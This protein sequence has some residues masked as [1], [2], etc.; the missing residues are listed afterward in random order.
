MLAIVTRTQGQAKGL[1][2]RLLASCA[3]AGAILSGGPAHASATM[4]PP[5]TGADTAFQ[6]IGTVVQ[7]TAQIVQ[8]PTLDTITVSTADTII[9]FTPFDTANGGG[10]ITFLPAGR[11]GLFQNDP[12]SGVTNFTVL[13]RIVPTDA[14]RAI[15]FD[16]TVQSRIADATGGSAPGGRILFYSPGGIIA[17]SSSVFDV[18]SLVLS[19]A[20][21]TFSGPNNAFSFNSA[22]PGTAVDINNGASILAQGTGSF[23]ALVAPRIIQSGS[24]R[25][26]GSVA[27][28][29]AEAVDVTIQNNLFNISFTQ[30]TDG[31]TAVA[32]NG[33]TEL[34][35]AAGDA[36]PQRIYIAAVPKNDAITTLV[37]GT[38]GYS[39]ATSASIQN[40]AVILSAGRDVS[41]SGYGTNFTDFGG[42]NAPANI[43][44]GADSSTIFNASLLTNATGDAL[45]APAAG[46]TIAF[47][48][49]VIL[50]ADRLAEV[51]TVANSNA[52]FA[53]NLS[54]SSNNLVSDA[55]ARVIALG[56]AGYGDPG[57][58]ST[59]GVITVGG[60][61]LINGGPSL[62]ADILQKSVA[63]LIADRG[64]ISIGGTTQ[65]TAA[66]DAF[67][68]ETLNG[69]GGSAL[70]RVGAAGSQLSLG[71]LSVSAGAVAGTGFDQTQTSID[72]SAT[73][74]SARIEVAGGS[75]TAGNITVD[76]DAFGRPG[77][78]ATAG[79]SAFI[80]SGGSIDSALL[81][82]SAQ[83]SIANNDDAPPPPAATAAQQQSQNAAASSSSQMLTGGMIQLDVVDTTVNVDGDLTLNA[84]ANGSEGL[85]GLQGGTIGITVDNGSLNVSGSLSA[86]ASAEESASQLGVDPGLVRGGMITAS[87]VN[88]GALIASTMDY[89]ANAASGG[90]ATGGAVSLTTNSGGSIQSVGTI[91]VAAAAAVRSL[92][93]AGDATGGALLV[94]INSGAL[95]SGSLVLDASA[96]GG[97]AILGGVGGSAT[98]GTARVNISSGDNAIEMFSL[99]TNASGGRGGNADG[100]IGQG[101]AGGGA[102]AGT[103]EVNISGGAI[104]TAG[105]VLTSTAQGGN[106]G[107]GESGGAG[108][109]ASGGRAAVLTSEAS[110]LRFMQLGS[111]ALTSSVDA[112][113]RGGSGGFGDLMA[114]G[115]GGMAAGGTAML[116]LAGA[117]IAANTPRFAINLSANSEAAGGIGGSSGNS[118]GGAGGSAL[119][120]NA[121]IALI[122]NQIDFGSVALS[123]RGSGG[124]GGSAGNAGYGSLGTG[125]AG[126]NG[127]GGAASVSITAPATNM[128]A[129]SIANLA[130]ATEAVGGS[131]GAGITGGNG[132]N[133]INNGSANF[134]HGGGMVAVPVAILTTNSFGG[135]GGSGSGGTDGNGGNSQ[136][137]TAAISAD[138][139]STNLGITV[140]GLSA[141]ARGGAGENG[142]SALGGTTGFNIGGGATFAGSILGLS[143]DAIV[144]T[145]Q[146]NIA[147]G[148]A[149]GGSASV[150]I[151]NGNALLTGSLQ[152]SANGDA[153]LGAGEG[154]TVGI[155]AT[156]GTLS[157]PSTIAS[158]NGSS[159]V[160]GMEIGGRGGGIN[161]RAL[162][163]GN[164][165]AGVLNLGSADLSASGFSTLVGNPSAMGNAAAG[166]IDIAAVGGQTSAANFLTLSAQTLGRNASGFSPNSGVFLTADQGAI[167]SNN[168]A[169]LLSDE[170]ITVSAMGTGNLFVGNTLNAEAL[171]MISVDHIGRS[172]NADTILAANVNLDAGNDVAAMP[173]TRIRSDNDLNIVSRMGSVDAHDLVA[174]DDIAVMANGAVNI[175]GLAQTTGSVNSGYGS[176]PSDIIIDS[177]GDVTLGSI[178]ANASLAVR[179]GSINGINLIAGEDIALRSS[180]D[181]MVMAG[182]AGDDIDVTT[183]GGAIGFGS[184]TTTG[185]G[186]DNRRAMLDSGIIGFGA[187]TF[188][189]SNILANA[190]AGISVTNANAR[191]TLGLRTDNIINATTLVAGEDA[192]FASSGSTTIGSV[193][194]GDDID[195]NAGGAITVL[196]ATSMGN[197]A[198]DR[199]VFLPVGSAFFTEENLTRSNIVAFS[200]TAVTLGSSA[201]AMMPEISAAASI[202]VRSEG[203]I[204][205]SNIAAGEDIAL[206]ATGN[207]SV[208][209]ASAGD[210]FSALSGSGNITLTGIFTN[211]NGADDRAVDFGYGGIG[212]I[213]STAND[214]NIVANAGYGSIS[215]GTLNA[216]NDL[217]A[218][219]FTITTV[220]TGG[221]GPSLVAGRDISLTGQSAVSIND[222]TAGRGFTLNSN[223]TASIANVT[224]GD[225]ILISTMGAVN[226]TGLLLTNGLGAS[227]SDS[228]IEVA[229]GDSFTFNAINAKDNFLFSSGSLSGNSIAAGNAV[230]IS[231]ASASANAVTTNAGDIAINAVN[232]SL[233]ATSAGQDLIID[234]GNAANSSITLL[235]TSAAR[236]IR[237]SG[238]TNG[239]SAMSLTAG[240]D[241]DVIGSGTASISAALTTGSFNSGYG[242]DPSDITLTAASQ[243][244]LGTIRAKDNLT[245]TTADATIANMLTADR[246]A[247]LVN[248]G[249]LAE[250]GNAS[251]T[252]GAVTINADM[253]DAVALSA[254]TDVAVNF[255]A[256][257]VLDAV[258]AGQDVAIIG[259][260]DATIGAVSAGRDISAMAGGD[261][262]IASGSAGRTLRNTSTNLSATTLNAGTDVVI[263]TDAAASLGIT[264]AGARIVANAGTSIDFTQ[265]MSGASTSLVAGT[266]ITGGNAN[267]ATTLSLNANGGAAAF[268]LLSSGG[269]TVITASRAITGNSAN[270][271]GA[272]T[273]SSGAEGIT[274][275][276]LSSGTGN[277]LTVTAANG[278]NAAITSATS[279]L[280]LSVNANI[281]S[282]TT[283]AAARDVLYTASSNIVAGTT[284]AGR[285]ATFN[286]AG[287]IS[288]NTTT[289]VANI[290]ANSTGNASLMTSTADNIFV[291]T[292][293]NAT[294]GEANA[295]T[296]IG[297]NAQNISGTMLSAGEDINLIASGTANIATASA[298]DDF[299]VNAANG[300][301]L[302]SIT[303]TAA[304][305]DDR[306]LAFNAPAFAIVAS[307]ADGS[308]IRIT[309]NGAVS[310]ANLDAGD[311][312]RITSGNF[313]LTGLAKTRGLGVVGSGSDVSLN[314]AAAMIARV[315]AFD[316]LSVDAASF[317][318]TNLSAGGLIGV[319]T[320]GDQA[321]G[322]ANA[323]RGPINGISAL[324]S[325]S[326][327]N[328]TTGGTIN[329]NAGNAISGGN[330]SASGTIQFTSGAGISGDM[331]RAAGDILVNGD[332]ISLA[333]ATSDSSSIILNGRDISVGTANA[334]LDVI[335]DTGTATN[336]RIA[337]GNVTAARDIM[338]LGASNGLT[339]TS[340]L[341]GDDIDVAITG[342]A[343][344]TTARTTGSFNAG[345]GDHGYGEWGYG[346]PL[347][348]EDGYG[349]DLSNITL[350]AAQAMIGT[351]Q[352]FDN[353]TL[354]TMTGTMAGSVIAD[355]GAVL[356]N[357][358]TSANIM[359]ATATL[360]SVTLNADAVTADTVN[361]A[362]DVSVNFGANTVLGTVVAGDMI[363]VSGAGNATFTSLTSGD[364][365]I[366]MAGGSVTGGS[367][368]AATLLSV[369]ADSIDADSLTSVNNDVVAS[370]RL[371]DIGTSSAARDILIDTRGLANSAITLG[372]ADAGRDIAISGATNGIAATTLRAGD[373]IDIMATGNLT[374]STATAFDALTINA[375]TASRIMAASLL[376]NN[377]NLVVSGADMA[378]FGTVEATLG[379]VQLASNRITATAI[380]AGT[381][382][383][384][385]Y[386]AAAMIGNVIAGTAIQVGGTGNLEFDGLRSGSATA[387]NVGGAILG[388]GAVAAGTSFAS[389]SSGT[390]TS[391]GAITAATTANITA[392]RINTADV[393]GGTGVMLSSSDSISAGAVTATAND[394]NVRAV[395]GVSLG[396][397]NAGNSIAL[398]NMSNAISTGA[399]VSGN[400]VSIT[401]G[402][403]ITL[404]SATAADD[405]VI[406]GGA[407][408]TLGT[409]LTRGGLDQ[410]ANGNDIM[411]RAT[412]PINISSA[413]T[414]P[415]A[416]ANSDISLTSTAGSISGST[417]TARGAVT[418][419]AATAL[420]VGIA[421]AGSNIALT[422]QSVTATTLTAATDISATASGTMMLGTARATGGNLSLTA[423]GTLSAMNAGA[424]GDVRLTSSN[425]GNITTGT[426]S[427]GSAFMGGTSGGA[428]GAGDI[429]I[430]ADGS[431]TMT[432]GSS[433]GR[434]LNVTARNLI[435]VGGVANGAAIDLRS[436]D[437]AINTTSGRIGE[438]GRTTLAQLTNTGTGVTTIGGAG[439]TTGFSLSN[440]EAQR[441][442]AGDIIIT[443]ARTATQPAGTQAAQTLN[444]AAPDVVL[445]TLT[446]TGA[447]GQTGATAG[448]IGTT[449]RLRIETPGKLRTVGAVAISNLASANR[450]QVNAAQSIEVDA[451]TGSISLSGAAGA[452]GGTIELTAPSVIAAGLPAIAAVAAAVDGRAVNDRLA[453]NDNAIS[454]AGAFSA[455]AIIVNVSNGFFVQNSGIKEL[456][457]FSFGDRRGITV[458]AGGLTINAASPTTRIFVSGRQLQ[459]N[460][461]FITGIDFLRAQT[462]NGTQIQLSTFPPTPFDATSTINGCA[463]VTAST[464]LVTI[465]GGSLAR[466]VT[467]QSDDEGSSSGGGNGN[468][469][470]FFRFEFKSLDASSFAPVIDDPVTGVGNDDLYAL[471][472]ARD[473][474]DDQSLESCA[475]ADAEPK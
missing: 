236:D 92:E 327:A 118:S 222:A 467:N 333:S 169:T 356:V 235:G 110:A 225:D 10:P 475:K 38:L 255:G 458:G 329:L 474:N 272:L 284:S 422:G 137:G 387:L 193:T 27:Y 411:V 64:H 186:A 15:R 297:V 104:R 152:L 103:A 434:N 7:G 134:T 265:L 24:V 246:G 447:T 252:L 50:N 141:N 138:G 125:G 149:K 325:I 177:A 97:D 403:T 313:T 323:T 109:T 69:F 46:T 445:D 307:A 424:L 54:V 209:K 139:A 31:G 237:L 393:T 173:G 384:V 67:Q 82:I 302:G 435:S 287:M 406:N 341:A 99:T 91:G 332:M 408:V 163:G 360:G 100:N 90:D 181:I 443:A 73:G 298:G 151:N 462:I 102:V 314:A 48:D 157:T 427:S 148:P 226:A 146:N 372:T 367:A 348:S 442:F 404:A 161:I 182:M 401:N 336:S 275:T 310:A 204:T 378:D 150:A 11:T 416:L 154:G 111:S 280:D 257:A 452:L 349:A 271:G 59:A 89:A 132:G 303:A 456:S 39:A 352:A 415:N 428:P 80:A 142:G 472:D 201:A 108:G 248:G 144:T 40:G 375:S 334:G 176:D 338:L 256:A 121:D 213:K 4:S 432:D 249:A 113:A 126:G 164:G 379:Q 337:L 344:I 216:A 418:L 429:I 62:Q 184:V 71:E 390:F 9:N 459:P 136:A 269:N 211:A 58:G 468:N 32:H 238:G 94:N 289:A 301:T 29:A 469:G 396:S 190:L 414:M 165:V 286:A 430:N 439:V 407:S 218:N 65:V 3:M 437:I 36:S 22:A 231:A 224:A 305:R 174:G 293:G 122:N 277:N 170:S 129:T 262:S 240:D 455:N 454:D 419:G 355:R 215:L 219:A 331:I 311:D 159:L 66:D 93:S 232:V 221:M 241:I 423:A 312:I 316:N 47:N 353:V 300:I 56:E 147:A 130:I 453:I 330:A 70:V 128:V 79:S 274:A 438:Q 81:S 285:N 374:L 203:V 254:A 383:A 49:D 96:V 394:V 326:F 359:N 449:G 471:Y 123:T 369:T 202:A 381:D 17:S 306:S 464:C 155:F 320:S 370:A 373:D 273:L 217:T 460:G 76:S 371:S 296:M 20:D 347:P 315:E 124:S 399:L 309:S 140:A 244:M 87:V 251:A 253:V 117:D 35:R 210:D 145:N 171:N 397:A 205:A 364:S 250:I 112:S 444:A 425:G 290:S 21:I 281:V 195:L 116:T 214:S 185:L 2:L 295:A 75:F 264:T 12:N 450:L 61:L 346:E 448:N 230:I 30:G 377:G 441:I 6:G 392:S 388:K 72:G 37:S 45:I 189:R 473:C 188:A 18:G 340:L 361:A 463:I 357:G 328:L 178:N 52:V 259:A 5:L 198:D 308:D 410:D 74:G 78:T 376:A 160:T 465:D 158:A 318:A 183:T 208:A 413:S 153:A 53:A 57:Y 395:N 380:K 106:G 402:G 431:A 227:G 28:I 266:S 135:R 270:A 166:R 351:A 200:A 243:A 267:A 304:A 84:N 168:I 60:A 88:N 470:E 358:G 354:G 206:T 196:N 276:T 258:T 461:S 127:S 42:S 167:I 85:G 187:E 405:L 350:S 362:T 233:G 446:L 278:G 319:S 412:G 440:A 197:G 457:A 179:G 55:A 143:A 119:G 343:K 339:A 365:T 291:T 23:V 324:G 115:V 105:F 398:T 389:A 16:G 391:S 180:G 77:G 335:V 34:T 292:T 345:Y 228:S 282:V 98:G 95:Q 234:T 433:A 261:V 260:G 33:S 268:G 426:L 317:S 199:R 19:A 194:A 342:N 247:I 322:T 101:G 26:D 294:L 283:G 382:V 321:L 220:S 162:K 131:G 172:A 8:T 385:T 245:V 466:D 14:T 279:G 400:D 156:G 43:V 223:G 120:G 288:A 420:T 421:N 25:S 86:S 212:F 51:R 386:D 436:T 242:S 192:T 175:T 451:A 409:A 239:I 41:D 13:N 1:Q 191:D 263:L 114:G 68:N 299:D 368:T 133:A 229:T 363:S 107:D 417:L 83:A 366:I 207:I 44:I 63:E